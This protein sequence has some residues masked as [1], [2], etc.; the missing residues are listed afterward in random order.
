MKDEAMER[1][2]VSEIAARHR[3]RFGF[4]GAVEIVPRVEDHLGEQ[5]E[6]VGV[7]RT[8]RRIPGKRIRIGTCR[9][10]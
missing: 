5:R 2:E 9:S 4:E 10:R 1:R 6:A 7:W 8:M 3:T